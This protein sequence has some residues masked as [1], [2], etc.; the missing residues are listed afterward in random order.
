MKTPN[1]K[2]DVKGLGIRVPTENEPLPKVGGKEG[3]LACVNSFGFGGT[4][5]HVLLEEKPKIVDVED[6]AF[7]SGI[8]PL[9]ISAR[10]LV[11]LLVLVCAYFECL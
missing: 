3:V 9:M 4:N 6:A 5:A 7:E 10:C 1:P 2:I 11:C 8:L